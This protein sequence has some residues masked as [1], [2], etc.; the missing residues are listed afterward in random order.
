MFVIVLHLLM[1]F[2]P[3]ENGSKECRI[4][5]GG[6]DYTNISPLCQ[7]IEAL[8]TMFSEKFLEKIQ[9]SEKAPEK[10]PAS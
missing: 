10:R 6:E 9:S 1:D 4:R 8:K 2:R 3:P 5:Y 7:V